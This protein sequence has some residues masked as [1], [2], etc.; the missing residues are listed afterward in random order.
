MPDFSFSPIYKECIK[1]KKEHPGFWK[2]PV[3]ANA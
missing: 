1:A 2:E 3:P